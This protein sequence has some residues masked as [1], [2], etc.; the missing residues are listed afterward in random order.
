M[1]LL[2]W[3]LLNSAHLFKH[4]NPKAVSE[5]RQDSKSEE[6][7]IFLLQLDYFEVQ[8]CPKTAMTTVYRKMRKI[9]SVCACRVIRTTIISK[10][11]LQ[12]LGVVCGRRSA[13]LN[14]EMSASSRA[15][16]CASGTDNF[17]GKPLY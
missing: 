4:K 17:I 11:V 7:A 14:F 2:N 12:K 8:S 1:Q 10:C 16:Q 5:I 15:S 13:E 9:L 3:Q 6:N